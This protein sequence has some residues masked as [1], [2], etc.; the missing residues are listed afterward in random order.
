M[1][2]E[3][4]SVCNHPD[5]QSEVSCLDRAVGCSPHCLCCMGGLAIHIPE[6]NKITPCLSEQEVSVVRSLQDKEAL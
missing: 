3:R 4:F 1:K 6:D 5:H 2:Q